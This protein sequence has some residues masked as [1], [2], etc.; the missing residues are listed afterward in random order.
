MASPTKQS[1]AALTAGH[2]PRQ[3][4]QLTLPTIG[5]LFAITVFNITDTFFVSRLGTEA[6]AAMGFTF[7]VVMCVGSFAMGISMGAGSVM[8]RA[9]G[10]GDTHLMQR[11]ATDGIVLSVIMVAVISAVGWFTID[12]LFTLLG[13][14]PTELPLVRQYM[15]IWYAG[16]IAV[17]MPPVSDSCMRA[18]G[19]MI[20]PLIVMVVCALINA[21]LDPILIYGLLG[22]P[23][24]GIAGAAY[25]TVLSRVIAMVTTLSFLHFHSH[26]LDLS[27]PQWHEV[28]ASWKRILHMGI[29]TA[30]TYLSIPL[31]RG[32][33]TRMAAAAGGTTGVAA[34]AAGTR[35]ESVLFIIGMAISLALMPIVGQSWGAQRYNRVNLARWYANRLAVRYGIVSWI[36]CLVLG[37]LAATLFSEE[38]QVIHWAA[39]YLWIITFGHAG[40]HVCNWTSAQLNAIGKPKS[41][42][43]IS[44]VGNLG[45]VVPF[46]CLGQYIYGYTGMLVGICVGQILAGCISAYW[47][48]KLLKPSHTDKAV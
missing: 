7:P 14:S 28:L 26:L 42:T 9:V 29:P 48:K 24:L 8:A 31:C 21:I 44:L 46:A 37:R 23:R 4:W 2:L 34:F 3:L 36:A 13:A 17:I 15:R 25:A 30:T 41:A 22:C 1:Q 39:L 35:I 18:T 38:A 12:P 43:L 47:G 10:R 40:L 27:K 19:D 33:L 5:G 11:T 32:L 45:L 20:R 16:V 6:L